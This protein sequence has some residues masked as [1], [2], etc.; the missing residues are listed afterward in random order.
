MGL[1]RLGSRLRGGTAVSQWLTGGGGRVKSIQRGTI[2]IASGAAANTATITAVDTANTVLRWLGHTSTI[3]QDDNGYARIA[4]TNATTIT[5]TRASN[6][7]GDCVVSYEV[8]EYVPGAIRSI[9][10]GTITVSADPTDAVITSVTTSKAQVDYLGFSFNATTADLTV[11]PMLSLLSAT[12]VR[13][14]EFTIGGVVGYQV[15]EWY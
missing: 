8:I 6:P 3:Q 10:R 13:A 7:A 1:G 5:A 9:Q 12:A 2:T 14:N 4:L 15:V 11:L